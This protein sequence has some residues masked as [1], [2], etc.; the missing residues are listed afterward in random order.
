MPLPSAPTKPGS[1]LAPEQFPTRLK[2][3]RTEAKKPIPSSEQHALGETSGAAGAA[4]ATELKVVPKPA[5]ATQ[6][7]S[8]PSPVARSPQSPQSP[9]KAD[10]TGAGASLKAVKSPSTGPGSKRTRGKDQEPA[11]LFV[12]DTNVLMHDPSSLFRFEEHDVYLP[13]MTLEE[14]DN[15]KKGMSEVARN[16]RQVSRTLDGLVAESGT[17]SMAEGIPLSRLGNKDATGRLYFQ[18]DLPDVPPLEGLP[19]GKADNQI[20][21]VVRA[22]QDKFRDR[23][24]VLVSK[25]INMR[26]KAH[27]L[28]LPAEDYFNDK[29]LEDSD[30]LYSG[31]MALPPDFWT[32]HG[33]G[34]E[35]WQDNRTGTTFYRITGPLCASFL[36]NQF[37]YLETNNGEAPFYAQVREINGKTALLQTLR[38]Y[39]HHKNN[40]WG[41]TARNREQ[42]FALNLLM[43]PEVDFITLLGQAGTGKTLLAL[44][45]GLAQT[46]DE[47][48]YNEIII[49]RA[50]VPV[51]ED[52]G[53]LPGTEEEKM[54]PWMGAFDDNLEVLQK[55]DDS[56]GEWGRAATQE[57]IRSRLKVKSMNFMRGRTFVNKFVIIDEAQNLTPKQMKTL[58]TRAGPGTKLICLG[59]IAQID[60]PYL[61]E[62]SSGLT[63]V[64]DRFKGW[65]HSGH[66]TLARGER[67]RLADYAAEIL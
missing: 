61:T 57:L 62:G 66:V 47:K 44:A 65:G 3:S 33:K 46:L 18:T 52:I 56:A 31:V 43:N 30:L 59:N 6:T 19:Q 9:P 54:Q 64:V 25:D 11:K 22:L 17:K 16:A 24:V 15:H 60:T 67:S 14:L 37:V 51:G 8:Q 53:F 5:P 45:A 49:T 32:K 13:M 28:G 34:M 41:I 29:V 21:G 1:L 36:I 23:Q 55:T 27:A 10:S 7:A 2:P 63:Y 12:L 39:G 20:L 48:R 38:D 50:T 58:V 35:S 40:V 42:N 26:V 4:S